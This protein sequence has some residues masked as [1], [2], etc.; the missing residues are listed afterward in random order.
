MDILLDTS[1]RNWVVLPM[2][3]IMILVGVCR[4][5]V[6]LLMKSEQTADVEELG[7]Q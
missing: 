1:I 3:L 6:I 7:Y 4:H 5:Y 2:V